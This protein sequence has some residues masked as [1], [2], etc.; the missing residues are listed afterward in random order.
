[1]VEVVSFFFIAA[2]ITLATWWAFAD[3]PQKIAG[4]AASLMA[5]AAGAVL[6]LRGQI[7][8]FSVDDI[9]TIDVAASRASADA[10]AIRDLRASIEAEA[11]NAAGRVAANAAEAR[12]LAAET[13]SALAEAEEQI[14]ALNRLVERSGPSLARSEATAAADALPSATGDISVGQLEVLATSLRGS[15]SHEVTLTTSMDDPEAIE[16]ATRLK[17]AIQAGGW[18]VHGV[19]EAQ[20]NRPVSGLQVLAPVP[21]PAHFATL[22]GALGRAGLQPKGMARQQGDTLEVLVGSAPRRS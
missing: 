22:L 17:E 4:F 13:S 18:I 3:R 20:L 9:A 6:L 10:D 21:L 7:V 12:W 1:M 8:E 14:S 19:N 2:G 5:I 16:L 15:G 11:K